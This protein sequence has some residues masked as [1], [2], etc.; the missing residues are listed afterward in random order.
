VRLLLDTAVLGEVCHPR[1]Y[2]DVRAW[3]ARAVAHHDVL[4]SEVADYELRRELLRIGSHRSLDR[5]D[6]LTRELTYIPMATSTWRAAA[7][8][9]ATLRRVGTVTAAPGALDGDVLIA[10]Q[11]LAEGA[12]VVTP[13]LRH[14]EKIVPALAW[15]DVPLSSGPQVR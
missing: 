6:E 7:K 5:L 12:S 4:I 11:A 14:F 10:A 1:K 9:W 13:N 8:L 3:L 2:A 15:R